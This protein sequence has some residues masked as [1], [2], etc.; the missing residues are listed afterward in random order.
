MK[1]QVA[2]VCTAL[3]FAVV[4]GAWLRM[5]MS[6]PFTGFQGEYSCGGFG[7]PDSNYNV[8]R[9]SLVGENIVL[10]SLYKSQ[11]TGIGKL[12]VKSSSLARIDVDSSIA[13]SPTLSINPLAEH[14][15]E[16]KRNTISIVGRQEGK[17]LYRH[18]CSKVSE[19]N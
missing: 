13:H 9:F 19:A 7:I 8:M 2:F 14:F 18:S 6:V 17:E 15:V 12:E 10:D 1:K 16:G 11:T 3:V 5:R 4:V